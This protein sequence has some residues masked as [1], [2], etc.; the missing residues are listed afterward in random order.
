MSTSVLSVERIDDLHPG[1]FEVDAVPG[2][3]GQP[4]HKGGR[5]DQTVF[6]GHGTPR[7]AKTSEEFSPPKTEIRFAR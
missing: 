5:G 6:D 7:S 3:D 4:M 1:F 2:C